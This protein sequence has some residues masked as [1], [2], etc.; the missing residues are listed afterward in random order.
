M[1]HLPWLHAGLA[2]RSDV[3]IAAAAAAFPDGTL[4]TPVSALPYSPC[5]RK[6]MSIFLC[7]FVCTPMDKAADTF[8]FQCPKVYITNIINDLRNAGAY[9]DVDG[10]SDAW[11]F[12]KQTSE[13][14]I[15]TL[16]ICSSSV[17]SLL[18]TYK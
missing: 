11:I 2:I 18:Q 9:E 12:R 6:L 17:H 8:V 1:G 10:H 7:K 3:R 5:D 14:I 13:A 16:N 15:A 4:L